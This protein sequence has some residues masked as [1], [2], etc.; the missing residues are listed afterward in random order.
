MSPQFGGGFGFYQVDG[1]APAVRAPTDADTPLELRLH[2]PGALGTKEPTPL[3]VVFANTGTGNLTLV[4]AL[5]GSLEHWRDPTYDLYLREETTGTVYRFAYV[6]GRCG[7]INSVGPHDYVDLKPG[8]ARAN[9][10][11]QCADYLKSATIAKPGKY[12]L[13]VVYRFCTWQSTGVSL[14]KDFI[15][16]ET[17]VGVHASNAVTLTVTVH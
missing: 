8:E 17:H 9:V 1:A 16:K 7:D 4:D 13:W 14:G 5:D 6:G 11:G 10:Q 12:T 15:R 3:E 2:G